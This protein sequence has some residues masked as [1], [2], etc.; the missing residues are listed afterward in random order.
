VVIHIRNIVR[1]NGTQGDKEMNILLTTRDQTLAFLSTRPDPD[2][3]IRWGCTECHILN[4][5][6]YHSYAAHCTSPNCKGKFMPIS[7][8]IVGDAHETFQRTFMKKQLLDIKSELEELKHETRRLECEIDYNEERTRTLE[9]EKKD[10]EC[11]L[12]RK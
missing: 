7:L 8:P 6:T 9:K 4:K 10:I 5:F 2:E 12:V 11:L 1:S 3:D